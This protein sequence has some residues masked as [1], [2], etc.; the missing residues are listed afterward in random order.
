MISWIQST[1]QQHFKWLFLLL[2]ATVI[3]SFVFITNT[4]GGL[5]QAAQ[6]IPDRPFFD[7]NLSLAADQQ[8]L[9]G[10]TQ[11]SIILQRGSVEGISPDQIEDYA[12]QRYAAIHLADTLGL[13]NPTDEEVAAHVRS[14]GAFAGTDGNF[15]PKRYA[16][17][18]D[19]I[20]TDPRMTEADVARVMIGDL[21]FNSYRKLL[22]GPGYI[23][24][25]DI[26]EE[27]ARGTT[28]WTLNLATVDASAFTPNIEISDSVLA[29]WFESNARRFEVP[30]RVSVSAIEFP[31]S[32]F[33]AGITLS[34]SDL[35]AAYDA[36][37]ARFP[38]E[39]KALTGDAAFAAVRT[40]VETT[41]RA[42]R[43]SRAALAAASDVAVKLIE[44]SVKLADLPAFLDQNKLTLIDAGLVGPGTAPA[45]LGGP[46][47]SAKLAP[48]TQRLTAG[49]PYSD[50]VPTPSGAALLVWRDTVAAHTPALAEV[51]TQVVAAYREAEQRRLF[52]AAGRQLRTA[53]QAALAA[54]KPFADAAKSA[55]PA[56]GLKVEVKAIPAFSLTNPPK[57]LDYTVYGAIE[58]LSQGGLSEFVTTRGS[59]GIL[60]HVQEK[61][62]PPADTASAEYKNLQ[63]RLGDFLSSRLA[64]SLLE[65][66]ASA[67]LAKSAPAQP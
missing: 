28:K 35:R 63:S 50:P 31:A 37:P 53:T 38:A 59:S 11:L 33:A 10:D 20:K 2:L 56:A 52:N 24:P 36:N 34:D 15:D 44:Q 42:E 40:K 13:P 61:A 19:R 41:L 26:A 47:A 62:T 8:R 6:K 21:R 17:F 27:L 23:L 48:A 25:A 65:T 18:R 55:A 57:D 3:V 43:A 49:A 66:T 5:H 14:L 64:A 45:S 60:V 9:M 51:R 39:D 1:F 30:A 4:S 12:K 46:A 67:E 29:P 16:D 32:Q 58:K 54:G 7:L 22:G